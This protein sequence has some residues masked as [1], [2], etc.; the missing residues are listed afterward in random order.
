MTIPSSVTH[1]GVSAFVVCS[2]L[3]SVT[4]PE[5]VTSIGDW[6]FYGCS[7]LTSVTIPSSV[8]SIGSRAFY[9]CD[10][11]TLVDFKGR[12]PNVGS[13]AFYDI[14]SSATGSYLPQYASEWEAVISNGKWNRLTMKEGDTIL[15][16]LTYEIIDG[17]VTIAGCDTSAFGTLAIPATIDGYP[18]TIIGDSAFRGCSGLTSVTIPSSVTSIGSYAFYKCSSLTS[19]KIPSSVTSIG[20]YAFS[21]CSRLTSVTMP[22]SVTS[23]GDWAFYGCSRLTSVTIPEGVTSIGNYVFYYCTSLTSVTIP[24]GVTSIGNYAFSGCSNLWK[25]ENGVQYESAAKVVLIDVPTSMTGDFVIP[26]SVRFIHSS[27]FSE[28]SSLTSVTI[29][30]SVT[31]IGVRAFYGCSR[32]TSATVPEGVTSIGGNAFNGCSS[33]TSVTIPSSVTSIGNNAFSGVAPTTLTAAW[34]PSGMSNSNLTTLIIPEGVTSI[35][36]WAFSDCSSLISVTIPSSVTSIWDWAFYYCTSLTSVTIPEGVTSIGNYAFEHCSGLTSVTIPESVTS[37]GSHAFR[38]CGNLSSP[39]VIPE[40]IT[41]IAYAAFSRCTNIPSVQLPSTLKSIDSYAFDYCENLTSITIPEGVTSIG[42]SAFE[43][44]LSLTSVTIPSSVTSIGKYAFYDCSRLTS[45]D[46]KG[47]PPSVGS[48]VFSNI[49]SSATGS[50]FPQYASEWEAVITDGKWNGLWMVMA[51]PENEILFTWDATKGFVDSNGNP[52]FIDNAFTLT[53]EFTIPSSVTSGD[54][55]TFHATSLDGMDVGALGMTDWSGTE[56]NYLIGSSKQLSGGHYSTGRFSNTGN[57]GNGP[58]VNVLKIEAESFENGTI[59]TSNF[60]IDFAGASTVGSI[61]NNGAI[62]EKGA[63]GATFGTKPFAFTSVTL[64]EGAT[65]VSATLKMLPKDYT[66]PVESFGVN[67]MHGTGQ[68]IVTNDSFGFSK[69]AYIAPS[70]WTNVTASATGSTNINQYMVYW[71]AR[72][73]YQSGCA[74]T[75]NMG[76]LLYGYLDDVASWNG[77]VKAEV[78]VTGLPVGKQYAVALILSGDGVNDGRNTYNEVFS[79]ILINGETYSYVVNDG[80]VSLVKGEAAKANHAR[81]W[82]DRSTAAI[83]N[84]LVEGSNVVFVEGLSGMPLSITSAM[85]EK[86]VSRLTIAGVQVWITNEDVVIPD[87]SKDHDVISVNFLGRA[88]TTLVTEEAGLVPANGWNNLSGN[89]GTVLSLTVW[90]D[91]VSVTKPVELTYSANNVWSWA[92]ATDD[93]LKGYLDDNGAQPQVS[94]TNI[95]FEEYSAIVY[96]ATDVGGANIKPVLINGAYY[97][98]TKMRMPIGY[99]DRVIEQ[100]KDSRLWGESRGLVGEYGRNALRVDGLSG[101][102]SIIGARGNGI[103]RNGIAAI[104]IVNTGAPLLNWQE[105]DWTAKGQLVK[106]SELSVL[107]DKY[108]RL[109]LADGATLDYDTVIAE[110]KKIILEG[111]GI[112]VNISNIDVSRADVEANISGATTIQM[113]YTETNGITVDGITYSYF[114][115]GVTDVNWETVSNWSSKVRSLGEEIR[116][117]DL[118]GSYAPGVPGCPELWDYTLLDGEMMATIPTGDDGYKTVQV[119]L[120]EGW[121]PRFT[122]RNGV[123][124][125]IATLK[126]LQ[127]GNKTTDF[128]EW[129]IDDASKVTINAMESS[130][131]AGTPR[132]YINNHEGLFVNIDVG[133]ADYYLDDDG[134]LQTNARIYGVQTV[135]AVKIDLGDSSQLGKTR[136]SRKLIGFATNDNATFNYEMSGVTSTSS[137]VTPKYTNILENVGDYTFTLKDDGYY[138]EFIAYDV[139]PDSILLPEGLPEATGEWLTDVLEASGIT[140]GSAVLAEGTTVEALEA[141]R[142]LGITP[143]VSVSGNIATVAAEST[144]EVSEVVVADNAVSLAVTITVEAGRFPTEV[145][146][147]GAVKLM[148]CDTLNGEWTEVTPSPTQIRLTRMSDT[149]ATLAVTQALDTYKFFKVLVK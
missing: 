71:N 42:N 1:I 70:Q 98:G 103:A 26:N 133:Q 9:D 121:D 52:V 118:G 89:S 82:G 100:E 5:G 47:E 43:G 116:Y 34:L 101:D 127:I 68:E 142:L 75:S 2:S 114:F 120:L 129:R 138:I 14:P 20:D 147:G 48:N 78:M 7:G 12:P 135:K 107:T 81:R 49:S 58:G 11:L 110:G 76:K 18:V 8:T 21:V 125:K 84:G 143:S 19:V 66:G 16:F 119:A 149:E 87:E 124:L 57:K 99:A 50:Y 96:M 139:A 105:V 59:A 132:F 41:E 35:G 29:P 62:G 15:E 123:H 40:G 80:V 74:T 145:S 108:I 39:I 77:R 91:E 73:S 30:S 136:I 3:T 126:K 148:V 111:E 33:L 10:R 88:T 95:P 36:E 109:K 92:G 61:E 140:S 37:I 104:Q 97:I 31:S 27:A 46:F 55:I 23:I 141:A 102:L 112:T 38:Y 44:C 93:Y 115:R 83:A 113:A 53:A 32:L 144:F 130:K 94:V 117:V 22:S 51:R 4:I 85:D 90:S 137:D 79:P 6:A 67:F 60:K 65:L 45:F 64:P 72:G 13:Y 69:G 122:V 54:V 63:E 28:C 128:S 106:V 131:W 17:K 86:E 56:V 146:L 24:E 25:D 134:S